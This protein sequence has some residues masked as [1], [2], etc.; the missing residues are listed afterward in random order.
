MDSLFC[1]EKKTLISVLQKYRAASDDSL[2]STSTPP[3]SVFSV[4]SNSTSASMYDAYE[5]P[6][7]PAREVLRSSG[8][9]SNN[10]NGRNQSHSSSERLDSTDSSSSEQLDAQV[11][12][13]HRAK[14]RTL[15]LSYV[16]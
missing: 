15:T 3:G 1:Y 11:I 8:G 12:S 2:D 13:G 4:H 5:T 14:V 6:T 16:I 10:V 9:L 7:Q